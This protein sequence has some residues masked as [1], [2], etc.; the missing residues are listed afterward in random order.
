MNDRHSKQIQCS[1]VADDSNPLLT[2]SRRVKSPALNI[3]PGKAYDA[4]YSD[5]NF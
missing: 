1:E 3:W 4:S 2:L 5:L